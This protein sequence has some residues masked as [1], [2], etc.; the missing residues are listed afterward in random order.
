M[1]R[2]LVLVAILALA[3]AGIGYASI[4]ASKYNEVSSLSGIEVPTRVT[5]RGEVVNLGFSK[6]VM[7]YNGIVYD[8]D[9]RGVYAVAESRTTQDSYAVFLLKGKNGF[10]VAAVYPSAEFI[11]R[12]GGS[13]VIE[14]SIVV[15]GIYKPGDRL[16]I[17]MPTGE[18]VEL[19]VLEINSILKGCHSSYGQEQARIKG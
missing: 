13:P 4:N 2:N 15:D 12:Y 14:S 16:K 17:V 19:P 11:S 3:I 18:Q 9:A 1:S 7:V 5:V 6:L 8:M 10:T